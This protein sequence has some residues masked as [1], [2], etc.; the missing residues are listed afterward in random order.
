MRSD[1]LDSFNARIQ[2]I[3]N[4][5]NRHYVDAETG[6]KIPKHV[7]KDVIKKAV[8]QSGKLSVMA[9]MLAILLGGLAMIAARYARIEVLLLADVG[10]VTLLIELAM[11]SIA[12]F[13]VGAII[14]QKTL[15]HMA[16]Q[17]AGAA[18]LAV[19][20][21]NAVWA[22]PDEIASVTGQAFVDQIRAVTEPQSL[23]LAGT[24]Y[25]I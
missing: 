17:V 16:C 18:F 22:F 8:K 21:H 25:T 3:N 2:V 12:A 23:Y 20:M 14:G 9:L 5:R 10:H 24:T 11:A 6:M 1:Q 4:P 13:I 19:A 7:S 15:R